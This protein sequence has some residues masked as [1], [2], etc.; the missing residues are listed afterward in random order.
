M[1]DANASDS[2]RVVHTREELREACD[3]ARASGQRVGLVPTMGALHD[4][5]LSLVEAVAAQSDFQ[6]VTIFVNPLQFAPTDDL[7]RYPRTLSAD[8]ARCA[9]AGVNLIF[10]PAPDEMYPDGFQTHVEVEVVTQPLEGAHRAGHFRG[11]TTVVTKLFNLVGPC[12]AAFGRKD[13]Q[14]FRVLSR[15]VR[16][17]DLPVTMLGCPIVREDDGLALSSRN[18]YLSP[19]ERERA[20]S[21]VT[22]LRAAQAAWDEGVRDALDLAAIARRPIEAAADSIDYIAAVDPNTLLPPTGAAETTERLSVLVAAYVG[23]TRLIDNVVLG[24]ERVPLPRD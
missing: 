5:H 17:L 23:T 2:P 12:V 7:D 20:L 11:V 16:D 4:G 15:M 22:G 14:Q 3:A 1:S 13:Y 10:A 8:V 24:E 19:A 6:V 18:R 21:L 9:E